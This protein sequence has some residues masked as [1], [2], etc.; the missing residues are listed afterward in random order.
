MTTP[1]IGLDP[2]LSGG[3]A[4]L[5]KGKPPLLTKMPDTERDLFDFL[6][7]LAF[8]IEGPPVAYLE[9]VQAM[10]S[11]KAGHLSLRAT[12]TFAQHYGA[13]R[14]ALTAT[15][16]PFHLVSPG[17]WQRTMNC[18][19]KGDKN[20]TKRKAQELFP[21]MKI[22]HATTD[23]LLIAAYGWHRHYG[24]HYPAT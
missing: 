9:Q 18:L 6:H 24:K 1:I 4:M 21:G 20:V 17:T 14:M 23:A 12:W 13:L 15:E 10:P 22:I 11:S 7:E 2:G 16:T 8:T 5:E 3:I 19:S